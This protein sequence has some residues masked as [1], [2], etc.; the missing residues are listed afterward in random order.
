MSIT[1]QL[2]HNTV[3]I[4]SFFE[5]GT[6][7]GTGFFFEFEIDDKK[8]PCIVT[9]KHVIRDPKLGDAQ[10]GKIIFKLR[11]PKDEWDV[12]QNFTV[13]IDNFAKSWIMHP[14]VNVDLCI[15][16]I[17]PLLS[18]IS[19][20]GKN[21]FFISIPESLIPTK[22]DEDEF[23]AL[24]E[25]LMV[26]YPNGIWDQKNNLPILRKGITATHISHD[27]NG[28]EEFLIDAAC[29][30]GS[31]GSPV[32]LLNL[33]GYSDK[34]GNTILGGVRIKFLGVLYAGPQHTA[35]GDI[36]IIDVPTIQKPVSLITIP[37]NL[38]FIIKS[39]KIQEFKKVLNDLINNK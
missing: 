35:S 25:I 37:N 3:R 29:F 15:Y 31:S 17:A 16:P 21:P 10:K 2:I 9:N 20:K 34:K 5:E 27:Y 1:E 24:E 30:P 4:E 13:D 19:K 39:R 14:D 18:E 7:T 28:R 11:N 36:E 12:G 33:N 26:G 22:S 38:G 32:F 6:G 23:T 8:V